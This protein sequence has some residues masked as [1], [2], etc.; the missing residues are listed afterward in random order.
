VA[1]QAHRGLVGV[2]Q[3]GQAAIGEALALQLAQ[4]GA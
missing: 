3:L 4:L 1:V 2:E